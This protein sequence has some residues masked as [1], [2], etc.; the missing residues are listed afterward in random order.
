MGWIANDYIYLFSYVSST[1]LKVS[2]IIAVPC[3][4]E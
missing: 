3:N 1:S 2:S 4:M